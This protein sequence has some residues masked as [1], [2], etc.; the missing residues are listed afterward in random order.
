[1]MS[2]GCPSKLTT[3]APLNYYTSVVNPSR[4]WSSRLE[5]KP[6]RGAERSEQ[7]MKAIGTSLRVIALGIIL[8]ATWCAAGTT[9]ETQTFDT[10]ASAAAGGWTQQLNRT[11]PQNYGW[12]LSNNAAGATI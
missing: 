3:Q 8:H 2:S 5:P 12:S 7:V 9:T 1:M 11:P 4:N 10:E 6:R